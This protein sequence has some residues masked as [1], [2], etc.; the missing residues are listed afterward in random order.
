VGIL[1]LLI[2]L[3]AHFY[4]TSDGLIWSKSVPE[5]S[6][7]NRYLEVFDELSV[8][9]RVKDVPKPSPFWKR[10]DGERVTFEC[11]P[12]FIGPWQFLNLQARVKSSIRAAIANADV[13]LLRVP[14]TIATITWKYLQKINSPY[15]LEVVGD[16]WESLGPGTVRSI[17]RP[18]AR[19]V[20]TRNMKRQC[21]G[22]NAVSYVTRETLQRRYP[23]NSFNISVSDV[24]IPDHMI[25]KIP[26]QDL[27]DPLRV[28][29]VGSME[30]LY[31]AQHV[32]IKAV[33]ILIK[34][35]YKIELHL[36]GGGRC[37]PL[38]R[39]LVK[40]L[41]IEHCVTFHGTVSGFDVLT[42][43]L[44]NADL[45]VLPSLVEGMPRALIEA[46]ARG[47]PCIASRVGGIVEIMDDDFLVSPGDH[48]ELAQKIA[49]FI[50]KPETIELVSRRNIEMALEFA[51][52]K[53][54]Q[55]RI[56][57]YTYIYKNC[58][59]ERNVIL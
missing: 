20:F 58:K 49:D 38:F 9:A 37:M 35:G 24:D 16:P 29:N 8:L 53:L 46:M 28:I 4:R 41:G 11:I 50:K 23:T 59:K 43:Y 5:Y 31:K 14:G 2:A 52:S 26:R 42:N 40:E 6:F 30:T 47:L 3:E 7:W 55:P 54:R 39:A 44:D 48:E 33:N 56:D 17:I 21:K 12:D 25:A 22:A 1:K 19:R 51:A 32:L 57:F 27:S 36:V 18:F 34:Q 45:F 10:A 15:A 13:V